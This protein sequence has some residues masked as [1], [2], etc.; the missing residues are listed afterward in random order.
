MRTI[1]QSVFE[2]NS[3]ST[4]AVTIM[5]AEDFEKFRSDEYWYDF[6]SHVLLSWDEVYEMFTDALE[7]EEIPGEEYPNKDEFRKAVHDIECGND[8]PFDDE[9]LDGVLY[10]MLEDSNIAH[11]TGALEI[12]FFRKFVHD[13]EVV[14]VSI[15]QG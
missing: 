11:Y 10:S 14:A 6:D 9:I 3:S 13:T 1:R 2:T 8:T 7:S 12:A 15:S 5:S 4:H